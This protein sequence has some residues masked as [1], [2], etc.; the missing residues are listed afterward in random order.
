LRRPLRGWRLHAA[1]ELL[2]EDLTLESTLKAVAINRALVREEFSPET[3][4]SLAFEPGSAGQDTPLCDATLR[5]HRIEDNYAKA[6]QA[7]SESR[8]PRAELKQS[9]AL[10]G[11]NGTDLNVIAEN[12]EI[13]QTMISALRTELQSKFR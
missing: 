2:V 3:R 6:S 11:S 9:G 12:M 10:P 8:A 5:P 4:L 7:F 13:A 1:K